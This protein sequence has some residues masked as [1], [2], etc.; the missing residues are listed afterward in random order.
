MGL[1]IGVAAG[2]VVAGLALGSCVACEQPAADNLLFVSF[3]TTR[4]DRLV[5][6]LVHERWHLLVCLLRCL[7]AAVSAAGSAAPANLRACGE[8]LV[9]AAC[10]LL[11]LEP[12][13]LARFLLL[14]CSL[15]RLLRALTRSVGA[16]ATWG[17]DAAAASTDRRSVS[18]CPQ[19]AIVG[20]GDDGGWRG[21]AG[22]G[23]AVAAAGAAGPSAPAGP[24]RE[25]VG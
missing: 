7:S 21:G 23:R 18:A 25:S 8:A 14:H 19:G 6:R 20:T 24:P 17:S 15:L 10:P 1:I 22:C 3:D 16:S 12:A 13:T 11:T 5:H 9:L 4:A 2:A